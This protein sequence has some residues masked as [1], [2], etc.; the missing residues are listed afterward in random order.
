MKRSFSVFLMTLATASAHADILSNLSPFLSSSRPDY[1]PAQFPSDAVM[2]PRYAPFSPA[3]SDLGVQQIL[4]AYEGLPPVEFRFDTSINHT[5]NVPDNNPF[6]DASDWFWASQ[7]DINWMPR[8]AYGTF[9][10]IGLG[11]GWYRFDDNE[12]R[13]FEDFQAHIGLVK[14]IPELDDLLVF[15]RWE[16]Q[17]IT[18]GSISETSY[19]A[20][21]VRVGMQKNLLIAPRYQLSAGVDAAFDLGA[22]PEK[23]KRNQYTADVSFTYWF[24]DKL[25]ATVSWTG[26]QWD[27]T[28]TDRED[29]NQIVGLEIEWMPLDNLTV[30]ANVYYTH[31]DS[32]TRFGFNDFE[33]LQTGVGIGVNYS[34]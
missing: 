9:L 17:R 29:C 4:Q 24:A 2:D 3:D 22:S 20:S 15:A 13:D 14:S 34:F 28:E 32:N 19:S 12:S 23:F 21:R 5:D 16:N 30:F 31:N 11:Q 10:D 26:S 1:D 7:L 25:N 33:S 18:N 27:F 8:L 6:Q